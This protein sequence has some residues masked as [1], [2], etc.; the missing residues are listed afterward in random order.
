MTSQLYSQQYCKSS[1]CCNTI[2]KQQLTESVFCCKFVYGFRAEYPAL[3]NQQA[4]ISLGEVNPPSSACHQLSVVSWWGVGSLKSSPFILTCP[5]ILPCS[6]PV[7]VTI[8]RRDCFTANILI[9]CVLQAFQPFFPDVLWAM[10]VGV[11]IC[12][13]GKLPWWGTIVT[14]TGGYKDKI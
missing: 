1:F 2:W 13:K 5:L 11:V 6:G 14:L 7:Y 10:D 4:G 3:D 8:S 12:C 9:F